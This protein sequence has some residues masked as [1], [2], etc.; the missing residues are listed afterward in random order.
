MR[1]GHPSS[2]R[3]KLASSI[4]PSV[5]IS[6]H[7]NYNV[8]PQAKQTRLPFPKSEI[9]THSSFELLHCDIWG[10]HKVPHKQDIIFFSLF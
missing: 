5:V 2:T 7:N 3:L 1:L 4:L 6:D 9:K 8:C 10:L